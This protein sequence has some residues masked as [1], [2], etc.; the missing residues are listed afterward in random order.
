GVNDG[1]KSAAYLAFHLTRSGWSPG[2]SPAPALSGDMEVDTTAGAGHGATSNWV[3]WLDS[4]GTECQNGV[5]QAREC[6]RA[7][8][9]SACEGDRWQAHASGSRR[10]KRRAGEPSGTCRRSEERRVGKECRSRW[11]P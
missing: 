8:R 4:Y 5:R 2:T 6:G 1:V 10:S 9:Q 3:R 7:V 11:S